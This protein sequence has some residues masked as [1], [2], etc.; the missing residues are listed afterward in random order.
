MLGISRDAAYEAARRKEIPT[1]RLGRLLRVPK[2]ALDRMLNGEAAS[3][4]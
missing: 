3:A 4:E 1:I 2:A